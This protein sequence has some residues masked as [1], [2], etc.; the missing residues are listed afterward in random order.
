MLTSRPAFLS[1]ILLTCLLLCVSSALSAAAA[2]PLVNSPVPSP[3][4]G[5]GFQPARQNEANRLYEE[6]S[7][8]FDRGRYDAAIAS[9]EHSLAIVEKL[10]GAYHP[11][12]AKVLTLLAM[13]HDAKG[14]YTRAEPLYLRAVA[15]LEKK[16]GEKRRDLAVALGNLAGLYSHKDDYARAEQLFTR[17]LSLLENGVGSESPDYASALNNFALLYSQKGDFAHAEPMFQRAIAILEKNGAGDTSAVAM[18]LDNLARMYQDKADLARAEPMFQRA[19]DIRVK[20]F[21]AEHPYVAESL[22]NLAVLYQRRGD[23]ERVESLYKRALEIDEKAL[24]PEHPSVAITLNNLAA[25]YDSIGDYARAEPLAQRAR[26]II[27]KTFGPEHTMT[28]V[29]LSGLASRYHFKGDLAQAEALYQRVMAIYEKT[30]GPEHPLVADALNDLA[31]LYHDKGDYARAEQS[32]QRALAINEKVLGANHPSLAAVLQ[33]LARVYRSKGDYARAELLHRRE[34]A[35]YEN[36][37]IKNHHEMA[38]ALSD[39]ATLYEATGDMAQAIRLLTR[40]AEISENTL[41]HI[42]LIGSENQKRIYLER[43]TEDTNINISLHLRSAPASEDAARLALTTLLRRKGRVLDVMSDQVAT[44]RR[45]LDPQDRALLDQLVADRTQLATL[46]LKGL[47][48]GDP[49]Q[50]RAEVARLEGEGERLEAEVSARSAEFRAQAQP[51]TLERVRQAIPEGAALVE[52][53]LYAPYDAKAKTLGERFGT[54]RY[55]AYVLR[56]GGALA[57]VDLGEAVEIDRRGREFRAALG[58]RHSTDVKQVARALDDL[59]MR[60]VRPLLGGMR[61]V[62]ISPDGALNLVPFGALVDERGR[63]LVEDYTFDYLTSGRDLLRLEVRVPNRQPPVIIADPSFDLAITAADPLAPSTGGDGTRRSVEM[64]QDRWP[65]LAGTAEEAAGIKRFFPDALVL[66]KAQATEAAVKRVSGPRLLHVATHGFF[67]RDQPRETT[68]RTPA[69]GL[70]EV[71][72]SVRGENPLLRSG[73]VL[74]GA[75]KRQSGAGEDGVL[76]ALEVAGLDLWG[77]R[78]VVLSACRTG[79][80]NVSNGEGVYGLRRAL[81][82][83]GA[84]SELMSLWLVDDKATRDLM[85][86]YYQRLQA[87]EGRVEALRQVQLK[88]LWGDEQRP[89]GT[90]RVSSARRGAQP[91]AGARSHPYFWASFISIGDWRPLDETRRPLAEVGSDKT[92]PSVAGTPQSAVREREMTPRSTTS[93]PP[94]GEPKQ[95]SAAELAAGKLRYDTGDYV[96]AASL[97]ERALRLD[98]GNIDAH[99]W[100]GDAYTQQTP[101]AYDRAIAEYRKALVINPRHEMAWQQ[102]AIVALHKK[103]LLMARDAIEHLATINPSN[104]ELNRLRAALAALEQ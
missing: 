23:F 97:F 21:G 28:A 44:L 36:L 34:L 50:Y 3:T 57:F 18:M 88:M 35:I 6:A 55:A 9:A 24:G 90:P 91:Q 22:N 67:V 58:D 70:G 42:L 38:Y 95:Q 81:V 64:S 14:D 94:A 82:L 17:A 12:V 62:L 63:Y 104:P 76:T 66:T 71:P 74:T 8:L 4:R 61:T 73:L 20:V 54:A 92:V 16:P 25:F 52:I 5:Q 49:A 85:L 29:L 31:R 103:S 37:S 51:V 47:G 43:L 80:G 7:Q 46:M 27:E 15:I 13:S 56:H 102:L 101:P 60:P 99:V 45:Q 100:L 78:L 84:E 59:V 32:G 69:P 40:A 87:G 79:E 68:A 41:T 83:A 96:S 53:A 26:A 30:L 77:T 86:E 39:L 75:N 11:D 72:R 65:Q 1:L 2:L 98:P 93:A 48:T 89:G 19:L 10:L 33:S